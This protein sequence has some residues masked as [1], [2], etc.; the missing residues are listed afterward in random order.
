M[1]TFQLLLSLCRFEYVEIGLDLVG[2][3][4]IAGRDRKIERE[5]KKESLPNSIEW[6]ALILSG[7]KEKKKT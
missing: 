3:K 2:V 7:I 4:M 6:M 1:K 5:E